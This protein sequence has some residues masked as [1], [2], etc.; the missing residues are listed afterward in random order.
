LSQHRIYPGIDQDKYGG[1]TDVGKIIRDAWL[2]GVL[3][4]T[5]LCT[6]WDYGRLEALYDKVHLAWSKYGH[7]VSHLPPEL[8]QR[9]AAIHQQAI[10]QAKILG[11]DPDLGDEQ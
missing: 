8:L 5:E 11:W 7:M 9:H 6:Q 4:E 1:M 3:P 10:D 2:F